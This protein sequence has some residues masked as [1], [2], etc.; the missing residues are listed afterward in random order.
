[1]F[2]SRNGSVEGEGE[3]SVEPPGT[4]PA[5]GVGAGVAVGVWGR[6]TVPGGWVEGSCCVP[7]G[8]DGFCAGVVVPG[9]GS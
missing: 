7:G 4:L 6:T 9:I 1:M 3:G 2:G 5:G 8:A